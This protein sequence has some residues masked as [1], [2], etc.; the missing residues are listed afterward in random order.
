MRTRAAFLAIGGCNVGPLQVP[1]SPLDDVVE[2]SDFTFELP[3]AD[4]S[5]VMLVDD[6][7]E[8]ALLNQSILER[9]GYYVR[10][11][12]SPAEVLAHLPDSHAVLV[13]DVEM[14][15]MSGLEL[16]QTA[17]ER[18]PDIRV[19]MLTGSGDEATVQAALRMGVTDYIRKPPDPQAL[20]RSVQRAFHL[21]ATEEYHRA[22]VAWMKEELDRRATAIREITVSTLASLTNALD[23]RSAHFHGHSRAVAM[24]AAALAQTLGMRE[25]Q[26]EQIRTAGLLH[27][28]G[29]IAIPD[30]IVDKPGKLTPDE[31]DVIRTHPD[32]GVEILSPMKHLGPVIRYVHE[33]HERWD[34]SGYPGGK[35]GEEISLG[36][37][38]VGISEAW[39]ALCETRSYR[40]KLTRE[41]ALHM[42][43]ERRGAWFSDMVTEALPAADL[44]II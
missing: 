28:V 2:D 30:T 37:Q 42:F 6:D 26:V 16:V 32:R 24:Q 12:Q 36:G 22:M 41:Q 17:Q 31:L 35:K 15:E 34:G 29:M 3:E 39:I 13:T 18:D 5:H 20:V 43:E 1:T 8:A 40:Q 14:P 11:F 21:R 19:I 7:S 10:Y 33:H 44:K 38:V 27:D 23:M 4:D 9:A 25:Q